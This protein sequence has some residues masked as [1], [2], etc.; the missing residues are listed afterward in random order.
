[1]TGIEKIEIQN[2]LSRAI[3]EDDH[4]TIDRIDRFLGI[5]ALGPG[6]LPFLPPGPPPPDLEEALEDLV[7][8]LGADGF[9]DMMDAL[10][11]IILKG[12][13]PVPGRPKRRRK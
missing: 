5:S 4:E 8:E 11:D 3:E 2:A 1:M 6:L 12:G 10:E 13:L 9:E 7:D